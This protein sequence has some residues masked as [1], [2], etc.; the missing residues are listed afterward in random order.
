M[1]QSRGARLIA[2]LFVSAVSIV[3][4]SATIPATRH[5]EL[6]DNDRLMPGAQFSYEFVPG[7]H[8]R[9]RG[10]ML[11]LVTGQSPILGSRADGEDVARAALTFRV[12]GDFAVSDGS[13]DR[14]HTRPAS[15]AL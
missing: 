10:S 12:A 5:I 2:S 4:T 7:T 1:F 8:T 3:S 9:R 6:N 14:K 15:T 11:D 13:A